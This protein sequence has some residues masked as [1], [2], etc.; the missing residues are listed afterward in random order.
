LTKGVV[1]PVALPYQNLKPELPA[2]GLS[3][4][5]RTKRKSLVPR[6]KKRAGTTLVEFA[7]VIPIFL[8]FVFGLIEVGRAFMVTHVLTNA[9]RAGCRQGILE[10]S[11]TSD[12]NATVSSLLTAQGI[13][14]ATTTV[15]VNGV[16][17]DVSTA[18]PSDD[19]TVKVSAPV[20]S[21]TWVPVNKW[22]QGSIT[23][24]YTLKRE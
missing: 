16:V 1:V 18:K 12:V 4:R 3:M 10:S 22:L 9:A 5:L 11:A 23:G 8:L 14:G 15:T 6:D 7:V 24:Q 17:A 2:N 20:S 21:I 19:I 13:K